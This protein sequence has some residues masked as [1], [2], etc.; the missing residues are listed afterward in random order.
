MTGVMLFFIM[1]FALAAAEGSNHPRK[2]AVKNLPASR[3]DRSR[4]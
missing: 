2:I 4:V 1:Q 3:L